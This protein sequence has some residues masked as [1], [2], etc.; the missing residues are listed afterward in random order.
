MANVH[1]QSAATNIRQA[2]TDL[3]N[4]IQQA[5]ND[6]ADHI[7][8]IQQRLNEIRLQQTNL[9][10]RMAKEESDLERSHQNN[11]VQNLQ[12]EAS[13]LQTLTN[14]LDSEY[15][16]TESDINR[17]ITEFENIASKLESAS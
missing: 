4:Q 9:V 17:Q 1:M 11:M 12:R 7:R 15:R 3:N 8:Q 16:K 13:D 5:K 6:T 2:I 14:N 10:S